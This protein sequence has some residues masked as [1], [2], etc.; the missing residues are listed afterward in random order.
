MLLDSRIKVLRRAGY[1]V[2]PCTSQEA[3]DWMRKD[4]FDVVLVCRSVSEERG[5]AL[6]R[7]MH[8]YWQAKVIRLAP[9]CGEAESL[10]DFAI[11]MTVG[12]ERFLRILAQVL[13]GTAYGPTRQLVRLPE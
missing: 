7:E 3:L 13:A 6:A 8:T 9:L 5:F 4:S 12:P 11:D 2:Q 1:A 10:Y